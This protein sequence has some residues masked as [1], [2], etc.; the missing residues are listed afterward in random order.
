MAFFIS[1]IHAGIK[2]AAVFHVAA[3]NQNR[4]EAV[5][6]I[7]TLDGR[8]SYRSFGILNILDLQFRK[9]EGFEFFFFRI[10]LLFIGD[11]TRIVQI[12]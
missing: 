5:L 10:Q 11:Q 9:T 3:G 4:L 1:E 7:E 2:D 12:D 6:I 8:V